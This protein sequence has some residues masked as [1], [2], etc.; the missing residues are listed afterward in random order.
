MHEADAGTAPT[1]PLIGNVNVD[2][3][4]PMSDSR[5]LVV[6]TQPLISPDSKQIPPCVPIEHGR[7]I[8]N[9]RCN[10]VEVPCRVGRLLDL[11]GG[12]D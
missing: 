11:R 7:I 5:L 2:S 6:V 8:E 10:N 12:S 3:N 4:V 1:Q 9:Y